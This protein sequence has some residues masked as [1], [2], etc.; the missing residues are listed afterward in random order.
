[1][2]F[3]GNVSAV[4]PTRVGVNR[5]YGTYAVATPRIPHARGGEPEEVIAV[6]VET[7]VLPTRV[8]VNR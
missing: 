4:L 6:A 7:E 1:M 5:M 8:G 3:S 2:A